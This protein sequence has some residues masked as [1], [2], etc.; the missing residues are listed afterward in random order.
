[1]GKTVDVEAFHGVKAEQV[2]GQFLLPRP[3]RAVDIESEVDSAT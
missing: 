1:M 2:T 3:H